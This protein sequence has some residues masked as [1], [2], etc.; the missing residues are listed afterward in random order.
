VGFDRS[1]NV[2]ARSVVPE[3]S[4]R[5]LIRH[6]R[7][8]KFLSLYMKPSL[9]TNGADIHTSPRVH[10]YGLRIYIT[11]RGL[12]LRLRKLNP[13]VLLLGVQTYEGV[14]KVFRTGAA[15]YTVAVVA[16]STG[17]W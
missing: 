7:V 14:S 15:I 3:P 12:L 2:I 11:L 1:K 10:A 4:Y 6:N 8:N 5:I 9:R 16:R 13:K 17:R